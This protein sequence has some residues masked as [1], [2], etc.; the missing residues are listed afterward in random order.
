VGEKGVTV[1]GGQKQRIAIARCIYTGANMLMFDDSLSAVD[2]KTDR[3]I[4][5]N[6]NRHTQNLT[7]VIIS[8]RV[9]TLMQADNILVLDR[10]R[11]VQQGDHKTL[12]ETDGI[13]REIVKIQQDVL[14]KTRE[15]AQ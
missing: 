10:G 4:R 8:Q 15:E 2:A 11:I 1:S 13:Y 5:G 7:C 9:N 6:L 14:E 12:C 3:T